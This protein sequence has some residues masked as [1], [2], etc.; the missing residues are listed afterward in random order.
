LAAGQTTISVTIPGFIAVDPVTV[1]VTGT[2]A[3]VSAGG[4][5]G[6]PAARRKP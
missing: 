2:A 6:L 3:S 1:N 5:G 4:G